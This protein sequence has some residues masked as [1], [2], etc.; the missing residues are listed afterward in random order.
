[1]GQPIDKEMMKALR[2]ARKATIARA[3]K[4]VKESNRILK[5]IREQIAAE[6]QTVPEISRALN[7]DTAKV[8]LYVAGMKKYGEVAEGPKDG[9]YFKYG[10]VR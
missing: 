2:D 7:V 3:R 8:M 4:S 9:D 10:L 5:A 1:M 6:P